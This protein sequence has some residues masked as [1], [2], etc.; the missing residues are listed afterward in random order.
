MQ[1]YRASLNIKGS[2]IKTKWL[3]ILNRIDQMKKVINT[4][5]CYQFEITA[6]HVLCWWGFKIKYS[7]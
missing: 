6:I 7:L 5:N 1:K 2:K 3:T 4:H